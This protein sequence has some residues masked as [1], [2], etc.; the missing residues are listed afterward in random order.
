MR[1]LLFVPGDSDRKIEKALASG[2]DVVIFDLED[3]VAAEAKQTAREIVRDS[4]ERMSA[5][6]RQ[7]GPKLYVR[8]NALDTGLTRADLA[9]VMPGRPDGI[10]QP[11][12]GSVADVHTVA[13][14]LDELEKTEGLAQ[15]TTGIIV[16]ATETAHSLFHMGSYVDAGPRLA[17]MAWGAE[18]LS[19]DLGASGNRDEHGVYTGAYQLARTL[20]LAGAVAAE[21]DP[22]DT[23]YV[24]FRDDEGLRREAEACAAEGFTAKMA[25]H[26]AQIPIINDVFTPSEETL[27]RA[28]RIIEAFA[29]SGNAGVIGVDG[30]MLDRP[31]ITR[32]EK[33]LARAQKYQDG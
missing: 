14:M 30:E 33:L 11:K 5:G 16:I 17:G 9:A 26:P 27:D 19:A 8:V 2:A 23:V 15:G 29:K 24:N 4:L 12:T 28:R 7:S 10:M 1:S 31:H 18:D 25:I 6:Q 3:S 21:V 20:C 13:A 22:I 32:A